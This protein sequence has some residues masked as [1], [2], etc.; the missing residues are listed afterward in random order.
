[1][2]FYELPDIYLWFSSLLVSHRQFLSKYRW[3]QLKKILIEAV[4]CYS[5]H[6]MWLSVW[7][8]SCL[9]AFFLSTISL[10]FWRENVDINLVFRQ[11]AYARISSILLPLP[12]FPKLFYTFMLCPVHKFEHAHDMLEQCY[13]EWSKP[14]CLSPIYRARTVYKRCICFV[15]HNTE[16]MLAKWG[17]IARVWQKL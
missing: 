4:H 14:F 10:Q 8:H 11:L 17:E 2:C 5:Q 1:M 16:Q 3:E 15:V 7:D 12:L 13:E 6:L 9:C